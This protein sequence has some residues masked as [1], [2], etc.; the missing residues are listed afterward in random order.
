VTKFLDHRG[1]VEVF[2]GRDFGGDETEN[3]SEAILLLHVVAA[4][5]GSLI[6]LV[7]KV[8]VSGFEV[9]GEGGGFADL[10]EEFFDVITFKHGFV[11]D[12]GDAT[13]N[14]DLGRGSLGEV[15]V[16]SSGGDEVLEKSVDFGHV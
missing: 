3:G 11:R 16:R 6:H 10:F 2:D 12:G 14:A 9:V 5:S 4:K 15:E 7:G 8:E 13:V 1:E